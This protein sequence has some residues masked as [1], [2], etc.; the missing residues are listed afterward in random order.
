ME[1]ILA[2]V[3]AVE[4]KI[5]TD[6][7]KKVLDISC[8]VAL[9]RLEGRE[10]ECK[11]RL[12]HLVASANRQQNETIRRNGVDSKMQRD[13]VKALVSK[14]EKRCDKQN[15]GMANME[16]GLKQLQLLESR[17]IELIRQ[18]QQ[19][20]ITRLEELEKSSKLLAT[21]TA[22]IEAGLDAKASKIMAK[23]AA[24]M[25][26]GLEAKSKDMCGEE[27]KIMAKIAADM[28]AGLGAKSTEMFGEE[29]KGSNAKLVPV[30]GLPLT[31][32]LSSSPRCPRDLGKIGVDSGILCGRK[33]R[34]LTGG[35]RGQ[36]ISRL[37]SVS[38]ALS[39]D[40]PFLSFS[41]RSRASVTAQGA[42]SCSLDGRLQ[43]ETSGDVNHAQQM[44]F[45]RDILRRSRDEH[46]GRASSVHD[47]IRAAQGEAYIRSVSARRSASLKPDELTRPPR[48]WRH[49]GVVE[50]IRADLPDAIGP[51][52]VARHLDCDL[53]KTF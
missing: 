26:T 32:L 25:E 48:Q 12:Q 24:D 42:S 1:E 40:P 28:E 16:A 5:G 41:C 19:D 22:D 39:V 2:R 9:Q 34:G 51:L 6:H 52:P 44:A 45:G 47:M 20:T 21:V 37:A 8:N 38:R 46:R 13:E 3:A 33:G 53:T 4:Q 30:R 14:L 27:Q 10:E 31:D 15:K 18:D 17:L 43:T 11:C 50:H 35:V 29:H 49:I 7:F 23:V 36:D